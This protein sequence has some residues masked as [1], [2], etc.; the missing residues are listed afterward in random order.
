MGFNYN[1]VLKVAVFSPLRKLFDYLPPYDLQATEV[2][3]GTRVSVPFG[4]KELMGIVVGIEKNSTVESGKLKRILKVLDEQPSLSPAMFQFAQWISNYYHHPLGEVLKNCLPTLLRV[5]RAKKYLKGPETT[6]AKKLSPIILAEPIKPNQFQQEAINRVINGFGKFNTFLLNGVTGSG[7]TEVYLQVIAKVIEA[8]LQAL[9]LI[10][11]INLTPQTLRRF[12][13]R[14]KVKV[15]VYHSGVGSKEQLNSWMEAKSAAAPIIIGTRSAIFIP[16]KKPGIIIV[17]E[18]HDPSFKQQSG[19]RYSTRDLSLVRAKLENIP[20]ILG[21]ATPSV[22]SIYNAKAGRYQLLSLPTRVG[23]AICPSLNLV[24]MRRQKSVEGI[25]AELL[26]KIK[27]CLEAKEQVLVFL[28]RRGY[29]PILICQDCGWVAACNDCDAKLT[30][31]REVNQLR[32]HH[33]NRVYLA[34]KK[35]FKCDSTSVNAL[36]YGT[37]R[38]ETAFK[39]LFPEVGILRIDRD[40]VGKD[41]FTDKLTQDILSKKYQVLIGTQLLAK[42]HHFP[43]VTLVLILNVDQQLFSHDF[44][45]SESLAQL[46]TQVSGRAGR[47]HKPGQVYLQTY[48]PH[49]QLLNDLIGGNYLGL[50]DNFLLE[51]KN[52]Q[53]PP[54]S[55]LALLQAESRVVSQANDFL[56]K[57]AKNC[58]GL[59][60]EQLKVWGPV[61]TLMERKAGFFRCQLM[62]QATSRRKL[63]VS[64]NKITSLIEQTKFTGK[65]RWY[66]DVDPVELG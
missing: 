28:N 25:A 43:E 65:V 3:L 17:D 54:Y 31:H 37:E 32:C 46:V 22:E 56:E 27:A 39:T 19:L 53:L 57:I 58:R 33:C 5:K 10:P 66:L 21:S 2:N 11:E 4:K 30:F 16:L 50:I 20:V 45:A 44:R 38:L 48:N 34:T 35:C 23:N 8:K 12:T 18:E 64:L 14:F 6:A 49:H 26:P 13:E 41:K 42:G 9:V 7:K 15:A 36:G 60:D 55:S 24:D 51:R 29:A 40:T 52:T 62:I 47:E 59:T 61:P 1:A 63:Q